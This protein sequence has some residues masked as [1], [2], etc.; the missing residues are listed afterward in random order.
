MSPRL[1]GV[2]FTA[3]AL[4]ACDTISSLFDEEDDDPFEGQRVSV[5][6]LD[7]VPEADPRIQDLIVRLPPPQA[8][9]HWPQLG[10]FPDH[11]MH[12]LLTDGPL[13]EIWSAGIGEG[14]SDE[15][16]LAAIPVVANGQIYAMDAEG[17][18]SSF[19]VADGEEL[20]QIQSVPEDEEE[21]AL[22]GGLAYYRGRL[23]VTTG[24]GDVLALDGAEGKEIWRKRVGAPLRAAP[25]VSN[26]RLFTVS[27]DNKL[28]ALDIDDGHELWTHQGISETA[29]LFGAASPAVAEDI[30]I[31]A[32]S[33]GEIFALQVENG[34]TVWSD[35]LSF[36][37]RVS[38]LGTLSDINGSP[39]ID[40]GQVLALSH[41]GR[42]VAIDLRRGNRL[43]E[44]ELAG[45]QMPWVAGDFL[46]VMTVNSEILCLSRRDGRIRW[47]RPLTRFE[48][49]EDRTGEIFWSGPL[50]VSDRL[51]VVSSRGDALSV[52]PYT[53]DILG[54]IEFP[55]G[56]ELAPIV[57]DGTVYVLTNEGEIVALK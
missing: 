32:Y 15:F 46:F 14:S 22:G 29:R 53:G 34:R 19:A 1:V 45:T 47:V 26:G 2:V 21:D 36:A 51:I 40:H 33:S 10:G 37:G 13:E 11:A 17:Q 48:D 54:R 44:Q 3:I 49:P 35:T 27:N 56:V 25:T 20:W 9:I 4:G 7:P 28:Y 8:T 55:D 24:A 52:S 38:T 43:W 57:A 16:Q 50:L 31:A 23:F 41:A 18:V 5:L 12:H 6:A 39:V 42:L 30:V